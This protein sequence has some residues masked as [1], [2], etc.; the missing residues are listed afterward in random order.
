MDTAHNV[1]DGAITFVMLFVCIC[2]VAM[3][4][5]Q[6]SEILVLNISF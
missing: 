6:N 4:L 3:D 2:V 5:L 1:I